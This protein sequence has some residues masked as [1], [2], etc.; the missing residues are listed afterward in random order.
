MQTFIRIVFHKILSNITPMTIPENKT[1]MYITE[2]PL[3]YT[4]KN[5]QTPADEKK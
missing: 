1:F 2:R 5:I 3:Y 4:A